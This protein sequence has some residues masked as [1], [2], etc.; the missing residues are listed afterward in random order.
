M[1]ERMP[2]LFIG[3][4]SPMRERGVLILGSSNV[5]H[6]LRQVQWDEPDALFEWARRFDDA[7]AQQGRKLCFERPLSVLSSSSPHP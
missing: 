3:H 7:V 6:N 4:G 5:V 1:G 2:A